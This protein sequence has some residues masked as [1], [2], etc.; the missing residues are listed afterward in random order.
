MGYHGAGGRVKQGRDIVQVMLSKAY[1]DGYGKDG[2]A[3]GRN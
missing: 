1:S 2:L 3:R